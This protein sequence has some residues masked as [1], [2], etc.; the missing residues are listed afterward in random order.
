MQKL[1]RRRIT[2]LS[3]ST[4][5]AGI[6]S[7]AGILGLAGGQAAAQERAT[8]AFFG[9][10]HIHT[11]YSFDAFLGNVRTTP[12]DAYNYAKGEPIDHP[13]GSKVRLGGPPLDFLM[14]AD[15]AVYLG[16]FA[17]Q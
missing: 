4:L 14:V 7:L 16:V 10:L 11:M 6:L 3:R 1:N 15:H 12:D 13:D 5:N 9:D 2:S 8:N 17:A